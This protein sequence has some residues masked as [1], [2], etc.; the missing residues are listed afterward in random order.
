MTSLRPACVVAIC[1][2]AVPTV[3]TGQTYETGGIQLTFGAALGV[4]A[5]DNVEFT[6]TGPKARVTPYAGLTFGLLTATPASSFAIDAAADVRRAA[7]G[8]DVTIA[9]PRL[10]TSY[11]RS[12]ANATLNLS[13]SVQS[14]DLSQQDVA[15]F[16]PFTGLTGFITGD[17][18]RRATTVSGSLT[19]GQTT[20][21][22]YGIG[23]TYVDNIY[24]GGTATGLDGTGLEDNSRLTLDGTASFD[25]TKAAQLRTSL[26][27]SIFETPQAADRSETLTLSTGISIDRPLGPLTAGVAI[28]DLNEGQEYSLSFGRSLALPAGAVSGNVGVTRTFDDQ[29]LLTAQLGARRELPNGSLS[30]DLSRQ[31]SSLNEQDTSQVTTQVSGSYDRALTPLTSLQIGF[32][33]AQAKDVGS[34]ATSLS[35]GLQASVSRALTED[36]AAQAGYRYRSVDDTPGD[37]AQS[38]TVFVELR[39]T[40]VTR[41]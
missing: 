37:T 19:W 15:V 3:M 36:W 11:D 40:F 27:Y 31:V 4:E 2:A 5:T 20:R 7:A 6:D 30:F 29:I 1:A 38:N 39:R 22:T 16:D 28:T 33:L 41:Y 18:T 10:S 21:A 24:T 8:T 26:R 25:L 34:D 23:A 14:N 32:D 17:A 12:S 13:A 35:A 9:S